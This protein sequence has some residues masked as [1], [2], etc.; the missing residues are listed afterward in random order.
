MKV[1]SGQLQGSAT[2][3]RGLGVVID[4]LSL[5]VAVIRTHFFLSRV[6]VLFKEALIYRSYILLLLHWIL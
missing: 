6:N 3:H 1:I 5:D 2:G 4:V